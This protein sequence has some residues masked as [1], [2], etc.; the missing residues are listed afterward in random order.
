L[1]GFAT[2][3]AELTPEHQAILARIAADLNAKP[4]ISGG[5]VTL[6]GGADRRG[7]KPANQEL[8]QRRAEAARDYLLQLVTDEET[9]QQIRA[10]SL[11]E[12]HDGPDGDVPSLRKVDIAITRRSYDA[13]LRAHPTHPLPKTGETPWEIPEADKF[14]YKPPIHPPDPRHPEWPDW[15][16]KEVPKRPPG[17]S[18]LSELSAFLNQTIGTHNISRIAARVARAF[19]LDQAE[20]ERTLDDAFQSGGEDGAKYLL[21]KLFDKL[22]E[23]QSGQAP[24]PSGPPDPIPFPKP[25]MTTPEIRF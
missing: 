22:T 24:S 23:L 14:R 11:G 7:Q 9:R 15:F 25:D 20:V 6:T 18:F 16:W 21:K 12:P 8:G 10:Y 17:P 4:L 2:G 1:T 19:G 3:S 5:Y 13:D